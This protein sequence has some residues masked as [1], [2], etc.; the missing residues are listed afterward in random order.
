MFR[1]VIFWCPRVHISQ[2]SNSIMDYE[3]RIELCVHYLYSSG[4]Q[5]STLAFIATSSSNRYTIYFFLLNDKMQ[6]KAKQSKTESHSAA[7]KRKGGERWVVNLSFASPSH[8]LTGFPLPL[9]SPAPLPG[10]LGRRNARFPSPHRRS[11][12]AAAARHMP[13]PWSLVEREY[14]IIRGVIRKI[15]TEFPAVL[16]LSRL[17]KIGRCTLN[18]NQVPG[19]ANASQLTRDSRTHRIAAKADWFVDLLITEQL[20]PLLYHYY[21]V[22]VNHSFINPFIFSAGGCQPALF[23]DGVL[24]FHVCCL[25]YFAHCNLFYYQ[26]L[27]CYLSYT[28]F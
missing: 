8:P 9:R 12:A 14:E 2:I 19:P 1:D 26:W 3:I 7:G 11:P 5:F 15:D 27:M 17:Y 22:F 28:G 21:I 6:Q 23:L 16:N 10:A 4:I 18:L 13:I 20:F 25:P 24:L